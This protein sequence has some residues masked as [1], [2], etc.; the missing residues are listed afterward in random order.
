MAFVVEDDDEFSGSDDLN[1]T[2]APRTQTF[3]AA[4][5]SSA[6]GKTTGTSSDPYDFHLG[7]GD[8]FGEES[9]DGR[10]TPVQASRYGSSQRAAVLATATSA[11]AST[12]Q[13][14]SKADDYLSKYKHGAAGMHRCV[15]N[16]PLTYEAR[17]TSRRRIHQNRLPS[18]VQ[19]LQRGQK[20]ARL[21][22]R[23][24]RFFD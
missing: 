2:F 8:D 12:A 3:A 10:G 5:H 19:R 23:R 6:W 22:H 18:V 9:E 4:T 17:R 1:A 24:K 16:C 11:R 14:T 21:Q 15:F 7:D 13:V 20:K